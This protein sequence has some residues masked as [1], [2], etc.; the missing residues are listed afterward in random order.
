YIADL[1]IPGIL[2]AAFLRSPHAHARIRDIDLEQ[3]RKLP[4]VV[5]VFGPADGQEFP[6]LP[7]LFP[8]PNLVPVAQRP[9][10][11]VVHHVGE[12]VAMVI[13]VN[14]YIAEDALDLIQVDYEPLPSVA[15][16]DHAIQSD[17]PLAHDHLQSNVAA[18][19]QQKV[20]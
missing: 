20:G 7:L 19:F 11:S 5:A 9:L 12:P 15:H 8:H 1:N 10:N 3:A 2:S 17:A 18:H 6:S 14:R 13:A 4:G 16:L